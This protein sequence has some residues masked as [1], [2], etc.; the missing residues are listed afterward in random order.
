MTTVHLHWCASCDAQFDGNTSDTYCD[1]CAHYMRANPF[2]VCRGNGDHNNH[3]RKL[4]HPTL[5]TAI[6]HRNILQTVGYTRAAVYL[7]G[8]RVYP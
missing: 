6:T 5:A 4:H 3:D 7:R 8:E 1:A 2:V